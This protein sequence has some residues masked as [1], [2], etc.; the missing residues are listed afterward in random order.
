MLIDVPP[1]ETTFPGA[2]IC[3]IRM[4]SRC[5]IFAPCC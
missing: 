3:W 4:R 5:L 2:W 1:V